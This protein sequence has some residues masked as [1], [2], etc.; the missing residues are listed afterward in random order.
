MLL[1]ATMP[2]TGDAVPLADVRQRLAGPHAMH[3]PGVAMFRRNHLSAADE[4]RRRRPWEH[5]A[6]NPRAPT[7]F[8]IAGFSAANSGSAYLGYVRHQRQLVGAAISTVSYS[9]G[10][11][12]CTSLSPYSAA[13]FSMIVMARMMGT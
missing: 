4:L 13:F 8:R 12:S 5:A 3:A 6:R 7:P 11:S 9:S 2:F 10:G 1:A